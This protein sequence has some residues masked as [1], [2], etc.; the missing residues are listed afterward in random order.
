MTADYFVA[1]PATGAWIRLVELCPQRELEENLSGAVPKL[2][3][4]RS[5]TRVLPGTVEL[6]ELS[7]WDC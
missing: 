7:F 5:G 3:A 6:Q 2:G 1:V 4:R